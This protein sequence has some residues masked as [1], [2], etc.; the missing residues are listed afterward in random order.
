MSRVFLS[1]ADVGEAEEEFVLDAL[2]SG[3]VAPLGPHVDAFEAEIAER[4]GVGSALALNSGT[5]ALHLALLVLGA[6]PGTAVLCP[7][8]TFAASANAIA[9]TG[10]SPVFVDAQLEDGNI[11]P[12]L[13]FTAADTLQSE[14]V[15][16]V[17]AMAVD[18]FGRCADYE[19]ICAGLRR[20]NIPLVEDAAES[21]G[22]HVDGRAAGSFGTLS[23][24]SFNG[25]K[26]MTT[27][28]GGMLLSDDRALIER[29]RHLSAQAREPVPW[30]EHVDIGYNY[31]LSNVLAALGRGQLSRLDAMIS[32]RQAIRRRY[33]SA[34]GSAPGVTFLFPE[35]DN[36]YADNCWL[37]CIQLDKEICGVTPEEMI[38]KLECD[39][40]EAR[41]LWKPMHLQPA[42]QQERSFLTGHSEQLFRTGVTL[43]SGSTLSHD[44][45]SRVIAALSAQ[46]ATS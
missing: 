29:A 4:V 10:A 25:N 12:M 17:A 16:V 43:P 5:A 21:L 6:R 14:G 9:Y 26:V 34:L 23:V 36:K 20:R 30:Y 7:T 13:L 3:W 22:A 37:T 28:G 15:R 46:L 41:Y 8:M 38:A 19:T 32:H 45:V 33:V 2:R 42:F 31:R 39:D 18:L 40:I 44:D 27:S 24:L 35:L 11:D 1:K